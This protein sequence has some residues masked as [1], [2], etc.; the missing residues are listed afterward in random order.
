[1][2]V[3]QMSNVGTN[4]T[5]SMINVRL[6]PLNAVQENEDYQHSQQRQKATYGQFLTAKYSR[7]FHVGHAEIPPFVIP[8]YL[9]GND[10]KITFHSI[11][12]THENN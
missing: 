12:L 9:Y 3:Y 1:M 10:N 2:W 5:E 6:N 8:T 11:K 7:Y 4:A